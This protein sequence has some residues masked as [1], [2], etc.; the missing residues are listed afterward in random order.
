MEKKKKGFRT[1]KAAAHA[2][3]VRGLSALFQS[4]QECGPIML[5]DGSW[6]FWT[7]HDVFGGIEADQGKLLFPG[8]RIKE[9]DRPIEDY[10]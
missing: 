9:V 10:L 5:S 4:G 6:A 1:A 2:A 7:A 3:H 8:G